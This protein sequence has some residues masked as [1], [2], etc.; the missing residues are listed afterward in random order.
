MRNLKNGLYILAVLFFLGTSCSKNESSE[1]KLKGNI[2]M[3]LEKTGALKSTETEDI[4]AVYVSV[5][6]S[7]DEYVYNMQELTLLSFNGGYITGNIELEEG[8]YTVVDFIVVDDQDSVV[9]LSPKEGSEL[10]SMVDY[11][12]PVSFSVSASDTSSVSLQVISADLG[13]AVDYGYTNFTFDVVDNSTIT[14]L[15]SGL[16][17]YFPFDGNANDSTGNGYNGTEYNSSNYVSGIIGQAKNFDGAND[18]IK[19]DSTLNCSQ[20]LTFSFWLNSR[21]TTG[22]SYNGVVICKYN[23]ASKRSFAINTFGTAKDSIKNALDCNFYR[24]GSSS[25]Y[26]D[27]VSSNIDTLESSNS[28]YDSDLYSIVN[29]KKIKLN[30]W[31]FCVINVTETEIQLWLDNELTV[32]KQRAYNQYYSSNS[33][34]TYIGNNFGGVISDYHLNG[35]LDDLRIYNRGLSEDEIKALFVLR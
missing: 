29:P 8:D 5:K 32:K 1:I 26:R 3:S 19:L 34:P 17:A 2:S 15:D 23:P 13:D 25:S 27:W 11:P 7:S 31:T 4:S 20:G 30:T 6:N 22:S 33:E 18:Y 12:L 35:Y 14:T 21:G 10:A 24:Y 16:V 28:N 9:Y